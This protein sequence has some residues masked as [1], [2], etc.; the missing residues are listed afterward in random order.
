VAPVLVQLL[1]GRVGGLLEQRLLSFQGA[2]FLFEVGAGLPY[3]AA[4]V[5]QS[6]LNVG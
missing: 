3:H 5:G 2:G 4:N 1:F 6:G